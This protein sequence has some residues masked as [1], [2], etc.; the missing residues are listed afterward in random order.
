M[1]GIE[2]LAQLRQLCGYVENGT[3]TVVSV[4]QDDA[5]KSWTV[6]VGK[7]SYIADT[8]PRAFEMAVEDNKPEE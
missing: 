3:D 1:Q 2:I 6:K 7:Q 8:M 4:F 5:T